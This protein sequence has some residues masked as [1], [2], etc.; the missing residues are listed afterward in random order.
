MAGG[1]VMVVERPQH[2]KPSQ[3]PVDPIKLPAR[4]LGV[5]VTACQHRRQRVI[6]ARASGKNVAHLVDL[7]LTPCLTGPAYEHIAALAIYIRQSHP[8][9]PTARCCP[10]P[11]HLHERLPESLAINT[12]RFHTSPSSTGSLRTV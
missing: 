7:D 9:H 3:H 12:E 8:T 11:G 6:S 2:F 5:E 10:N 1:V 4:R